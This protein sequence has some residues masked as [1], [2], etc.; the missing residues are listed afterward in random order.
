MNLSP[1]AY[2][3]RAAVFVSGY[4]EGMTEFVGKNINTGKNITELSFGITV[5]H[6]DSWLRLSQTQSV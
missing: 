6:Y 4:S 2:S 3:P 1:R 5:H